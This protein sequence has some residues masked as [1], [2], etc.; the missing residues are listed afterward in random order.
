VRDDAAGQKRGPRGLA[1]VRGE[2]D[3]ER[4]GEDALVVPGEPCHLR[5]QVEVMQMKPGEAGE[6]LSALRLRLLRVSGSVYGAVFGEGGLDVRIGGRY[7]EIRILSQQFEEGE[8]GE[9]RLS[10]GEERPPKE[11]KV[12]GDWCRIDRETS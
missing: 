8:E 11:N 9:R 5:G 2:V 6:E 10:H 12:L 3:T 4:R 7:L 1:D